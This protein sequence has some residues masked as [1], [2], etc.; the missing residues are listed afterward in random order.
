MEKIYTTVENLANYAIEE[1][2]AEEADRSYLINALLEKLCIDDFASSPNREKQDLEEMLGVLTDYACEKGIV[3]E[4][5]VV[6]RD[7][8]DTSPPS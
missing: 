4:N 1:G 6:Y 7:L 3:K 2:L 5:S 8:F